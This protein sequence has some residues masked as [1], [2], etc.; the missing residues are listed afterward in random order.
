MDISLGGSELLASIPAIETCLT[1]SGTI[2]P[3]CDSFRLLDSLGA[4]LDHRFAKI[5]ELGASQGMDALT[6]GQGDG[7]AGSNTQ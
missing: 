5:A 3:V 1:A 4:S 7:A 6:W 2:L